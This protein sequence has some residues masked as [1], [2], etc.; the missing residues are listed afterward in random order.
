MPTIGRRK[1]LN[2]AVMKTMSP[3]P[4]AITFPLIGWNL[5]W[6][7]LPSSLGINSIISFPTAPHEAPTLTSMRDGK[8]VLITSYSRFLQISKYFFPRMWATIFL[9][10]SSLG[11]PT[12]IELASMNH[13]FPTNFRLWY[14]Y[15][16]I[17]SIFTH[18]MFPWGLST[19]LAIVLHKKSNCVKFNDSY[20]EVAAIDFRCSSIRTKAITPIK[21]LDPSLNLKFRFLKIKITL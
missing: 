19:C 17:P 7:R 9:K 21:I 2:I 20:V 1:I 10:A 14:A 6:I 16:I 8:V 18:P 11:R 5:V 12:N 4:I 3:Q 13:A 15:K